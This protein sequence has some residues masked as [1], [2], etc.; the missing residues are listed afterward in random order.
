MTVV[1]NPAELVAAG[2][3][4]ISSLN[5]YSP[6][7]DA[8][9]E[10]LANMSISTMIQPNLFSGP[11]QVWLGAGTYTLLSD[12]SARIISDGTGSSGVYKKMRVVPGCSYKVQYK[13]LG[14]VSQTSVRCGATTTGAELFSRAVNS[15]DNVTYTNTFT[16][17]TADVYMNF[18]F[19]AS[20]ADLTISEVVLTQTSVR[21]A[22]FEWGNS[23]EAATGATIVANGY[24]GRLAAKYT[25]TRLGFPKGVGGE[26][27]TQ[28]LSRVTSQGSGLYPG[29]IHV[30]GMLENDP[31][32]SVTA[33]TTKANIATAIAQLGVHY[34]IRSGLPVCTDAAAASNAQITQLNTDLK[35]LYGRRFVDINTPLAAA[36]DGSAGDLSDIAKGWTPRS[37]RYDDIHLNN[38]GYQ[39]VADALYPAIGRT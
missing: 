4:L 23:I 35:A 29:N 19:G 27:S 31:A 9:A 10:W 38:A 17:S 36:N 2:G 25:P 21:P 24:P 18:G 20:G 34:F 6:E 13:V 11:A 33:A 1:L 3:A 8:L 32:N 5:T 16:P 28:I 14:A 37:L 22:L 12:V 7:H 26:T 15:G 39:V 30:L